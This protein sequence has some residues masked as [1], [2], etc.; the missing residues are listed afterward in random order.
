MSRTLLTLSTLLLL[1][2][3][4]QPLFAQNRT[5]PDS[6]IDTQ[7]A[8]VDVRPGQGGSV[9]SNLSTGVEPSSG[10]GADT[11]VGPSAVPGAGAK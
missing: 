4:T 11:P 5:P 10:R 6:N 8:P 3:G 2:A 7:Q 9:P 1:T